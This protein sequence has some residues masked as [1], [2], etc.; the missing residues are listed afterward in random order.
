MLGYNCIINSSRHSPLTGSCSSFD[1]LN[2]NESKFSFSYLLFH[3][4]S[5]VCIDPISF[6]VHLTLEPSTH[7]APISRPLKRKRYFPLRVLETPTRKLD[8]YVVKLIMCLFV[9]TEMLEDF[10]VVLVFVCWFIWVFI[11]VSFLFCCL[12][13]NILGWREYLAIKSTGCSSKGL[14]VNS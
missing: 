10:V 2:Q 8:T 12:Q 11:G 3:R 7:S 5:I 6:P 9:L 1:S 4:V 13:S 14:G